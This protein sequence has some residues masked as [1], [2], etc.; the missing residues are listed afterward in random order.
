MSHTAKALVL[1]CMDFR[2]IH[3]IV[4]YLKAEGL[5]DQYDDVSLAGAAKCL[6][7]PMQAHD[8]EV[9]LRQ[10]ELSQKLHQITSVYL[11]NHRDC[12]AYGKIFDTP[13]AETERHTQDLQRA[14]TMVQEKFPE[15]EVKTILATLQESGQVQF[16]PVA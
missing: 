14:K 5:I 4:H 8:T 12:G 10:I 7:D 9:V 6:A 13:E 16:T 1:H 2:F 15:L 11:I 3:Q